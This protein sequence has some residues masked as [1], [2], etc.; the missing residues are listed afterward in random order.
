MQGSLRLH[1]AQAQ[2][3]PLLLLQCSQLPFFVLL[4]V[5]MCVWLPCLVLYCV[6]LWYCCLSVL[7]FVL[8]CRMCVSELSYCL[9][10]CC[11]SLSALS[12]VVCSVA[13]CLCAYVAPDVT[14]LHLV[15]LCV[16]LLCCTEC[17]APCVV[18]PCVTRSVPLHGVFPGAVV[19]PPVC[20]SVCV[21]HCSVLLLCL[22]V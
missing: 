11:P 22:V 21:L 20:Y 2:S 3:E 15:L 5:R 1:P 19:L 16:L 17:T 14:V 18:L 13:V 6:L 7:L 10:W 9:V 12:C 8:F 4:C